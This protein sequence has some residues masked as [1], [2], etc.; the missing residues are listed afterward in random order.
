M[1]DDLT[2]D[3]GGM[4]LDAGLSLDTDAG[5]SLGGDEPEEKLED[6][7]IEEVAAE[8]VSEIL[9]GFKARA[10]REEDRFQDATDSEH[11]VA[12]CFQTRAQKEEFLRKVN[13]LD[14]GDKYLNG[15]AVA[16]RLGIKLDS[17]IPPL[18][19]LRVDRRLAELT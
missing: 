4:D 19:E 2:L 17:P 5:L 15:M 9:S 11:W 18:P 13:L 3:P 7:D 8:E 10:N 6:V 12:L 1:A 16:D 14:L